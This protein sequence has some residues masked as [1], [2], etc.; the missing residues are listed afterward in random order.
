[1][2]V[3][4]LCMSCLCLWLGKLSVLV[5]ADY[6]VQVELVSYSHPSNT[7]S[8][9]QCC[10]PGNGVP[11]RG[12]ER[13]DT[14][15]IYCLMPRTSTAT[16]CPNIV[17]DPG[18]TVVST[19]ID[20]GDNIDS[21]HPRVFNLTGITT[22]WEG[23]QFY[24]QVLDY[25]NGPVDVI[26]RYRFDLSLS[27]GLT[28]TLMST[29]NTGPSITLRATV[30]C[31][32]FYSGNSCDIFDHCESGSNAVTCSDRGTCI[33]GFTSFTCNCNCPYFGANCERQNFCFDRNCNG[34]GTCTNGL[35]SYTCV[36]NAGYTG[37]DCEDDIDECLL[38]ER[39]CS[40]HGNCSQGIATF[41]CSCDPGYT[42]QRYETD[43][44]DCRN[45]NG[46]ALRGALGDLI[47]GM[48]GGLLVLMLIL[49]LLIVVVVV[50]ARRK[51]QGKTIQDT[52]FQGDNPVHGIPKSRTN[53]TNTITSE[54][55]EFDNP[56]YGSQ[57]SL[58]DAEF[59]NAI[60]GDADFE[61]IPY[62]LSPDTMTLVVPTCV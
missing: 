28:N 11:C 58:N 53:R 1:M 48:V 49:L 32:P 16:G 40:G 31:T 15:F 60:Y 47:G 51:A 26:V 54:T 25:D 56:I 30:L 10:D 17:T 14:Y 52:Q 37:A 2:R 4:V 8:D 23:A 5:S 33:N 3:L 42:G 41:T 22:A 7:R 57:E 9:G 13:C 36:C 62:E 61:D 19:L 45:C 44:D 27:V 55:A 20:D 29:S 43:I 59:V 38:M 50:C 6:V 21:L 34:R 39:V 35:D 12:G 24:I 46:N 18:F